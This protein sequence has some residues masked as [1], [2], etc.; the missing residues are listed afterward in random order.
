MLSVVVDEQARAEL[1][2]DLD[3]LFREGARRMLAAAL[4]A[5][6]EA[7]IAAHTELLD[8]HGHRLVVGN[9]HAPARTLATRGGPG[10]GGGHRARSGGHAGHRGRRGRGGPPAGGR[11]SHRLR[12]RRAGAVPE[13]DPAPLVSAQPEGGR[14]AGGGG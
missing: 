8:E 10:G 5:E 6:V 1:A 9:G 4:E 2:T 14:G 12:H 7:Y 11:P 13:R 3:E